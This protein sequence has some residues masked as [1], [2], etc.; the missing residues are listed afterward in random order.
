MNRAILLA[1]AVGLLTFADSPINAAPNPRTHEYA[2]EVTKPAPG[3][4]LFLVSVYFYRQPAPGMAEAITRDQMALFV[5]Y[6]APRKND[7]MGSAWFSAT[8]EEGTEQ[9][10]K[11][12]GGST[13]LL[14]E[15]RTSKIRLF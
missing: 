15:R 6:F 7:V 8:G 11:F 4:P 3:N 13:T 9:M 14:Y 2:V 12:S 5:K 1:I 10:L